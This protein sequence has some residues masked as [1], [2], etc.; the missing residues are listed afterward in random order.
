MLLDHPIEA[1]HTIRYDAGNQICDGLLF[2]G[3]PDQLI[4]VLPDWR[5]CLTDYAL[6][7]GHDIARLTGASVCVTDAYG[8]DKKPAA[9]VGDAELWVAQA[10][11]D[12]T[13]LREML[14]EQIDGLRLH[15]DEKPKHV[16]IVGYCLGG[17]LAL[18]AGRKGIG[19]DAVVSVHGIPSTKR[20]M[21]GN[22]GETSFLAIH[23]AD[24]PIIGIEHLRSFEAEMTAVGANWQ[25][26]VIGGARHGFTSEEA[27]PFG[28]HQRYDAQAAES[29]LNVTNAFLKAMGKNDD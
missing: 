28:S 10:L 8:A 7:R 12:P 23:G 27:D 19:V 20:R 13:T 4:I 3:V 16:A 15:L 6:R 11:S 14:A 18:E 26:H 22:P 9:Y 25:T 24:D 1:A 21:T 5:G 17:A 29:A 2:Q